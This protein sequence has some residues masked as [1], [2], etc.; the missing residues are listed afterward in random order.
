MI[1]P[2]DSS[3]FIVCLMT[4]G[5]A[6]IFYVTDGKSR[7]TRA[8]S[9]CLF[10]IAAALLLGS[11]E[12]LGLIGHSA[13][14]A[15]SRTT[16][17]SVS[18]LAGVEWGRRIGQTATGRWRT[19][20]NVLFRVSQGLVLIYWMLF[21]GYILLFPEK[22]GQSVAGVVRVRAVEFAVFAPV[23]GSAILLATIS[24]SMLLLIRIDRAEQA[25]L[26]ALFWAGPFLLLGLILGERLVPLTLS[27]G[28]LI[29]IAGSV[30]YL[31]IQGQRGAFMRQFLSP[32]VARIVQA[33]GL[34]QVLKRERRP[35]SVVFCDLRG[36][37][38]YARVRDSDAVTTLLEQFYD[39]VGAAAAAHGGVVKDHAGDG[40]LILVGAPLAVPD[41][42]ARAVKLALDLH[43]RV[44]PLLDA[45][46]AGLGLGVGVATGNTTVGAIR[47]AGRLEY[48]AVGNA[49]NLAARLCARAADGEVLSDQRTCDE[50]GKLK[51]E[52]VQHAPE[53]L[54]GFAEPIPVCGLR[55]GAP[56]EEPAPA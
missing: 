43:V 9:L 8:L 47:G 24:I 11:S 36:F 30:R 45:T 44:R 32:E 15:A 18:I 17:E 49:V 37:T 53:P 50:M 5:V 31:M 25:R 41:H 55:E 22:A 23:L 35:L 56:A 13:L 42:A 19:T 54:K 28:L 12:Y 48:V 29:F 1:Q 10:A 40:V 52:V 39:I 14:I 3:A 20:S 33:E 16:L 2:L 46:G 26:R 38:A 4:A 27:L 34:E 51:I 21:L 6:L 7:T